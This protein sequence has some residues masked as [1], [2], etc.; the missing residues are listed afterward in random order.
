VGGFPRKA[1]CAACCELLAHGH[2]RVYDYGWGWFQECLQAARGLRRR[3]RREALLDAL[4]AGR[5][6]RQ[7]L[8][9]HLHTLEQE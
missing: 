7:T 1:L 9:R 3:Q 6:D 8:E 5:A 2:G 4:A